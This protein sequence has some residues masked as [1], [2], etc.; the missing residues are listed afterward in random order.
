MFTL[1][2]YKIKKE[3]TNRVCYI[4]VKRKTVTT[5]N[6]GEKNPPSFHTVNNSCK[7]IYD[8]HFAAPSPKGRE[9]PF[10]GRYEISGG[11]NADDVGKALAASRPGT[12]NNQD[13]PTPPCNPP[14]KQYLTVG[15][16]SRDTMEFLSE[17]G[18]KTVAGKSQS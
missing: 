1:T 4:C 15:C 7:M 5:D 2:N 10:P 11:P 12:E 8:S 16:N 6:N 18:T 17:C 3:L 14:G 9:C 13:K